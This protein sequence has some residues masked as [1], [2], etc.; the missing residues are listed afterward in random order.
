MTIRFDGRG[1]RGRVGT[2]LREQ[3]RAAGRDPAQTGD[4]WAA[5]ALSTADLVDAARIAADPKL[6]LTSSR[7][8]CALLPMVE[9]MPHEQRGAGA[10]P[11][12]GAGDGRADELADE[13]GAGPEVGDP[14]Q[15]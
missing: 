13:L 1:R 7:E 12:G 3:L 11:G 4:V 10:A 9:G 8:L 5:L 6:F 15:A 2:A 14:A